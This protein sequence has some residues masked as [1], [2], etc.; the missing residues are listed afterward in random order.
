MTIPLWQL[1]G[2]LLDGRVVTA[3]TAGPAALD[4]LY[5]WTCCT[6]SRGCCQPPA[7]V[8]APPVHTSAGWW[9]AQH[10][11]APPGMSTQG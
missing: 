1:L 2:E 4:G 3:G 6:L 11:Q 7:S 8:Q 9:Q 5:G 10:G